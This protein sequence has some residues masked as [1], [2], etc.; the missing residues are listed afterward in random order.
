MP[1][2][3]KFYRVDFEKSSSVYHCFF[4]RH[5][6]LSNLKH[7]LPLT[8]R[9]TVFSHLKVAP[10][11]H[12]RSQSFDPFGQRWGSLG[13]KWLVPVTVSPKGQNKTSSQSQNS[14]FVE[15][16]H[17]MSAWLKILKCN[18][19]VATNTPSPRQPPK[20][21]KNFLLILACVMSREFS[22]EAV[23]KSLPTQFA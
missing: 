7:A 19:V 22:R 16:D 10:L 20:Q 3:T 11:L 9:K 15:L 12:S 6:C 23:M 18:F 13:T 14:T 1:N 17:K 5:V 4:R 21:K 8:A 2:I